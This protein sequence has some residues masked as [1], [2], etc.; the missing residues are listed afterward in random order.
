MRRL[1]AKSFVDYSQLLR[2]EP[3]KL[4][5]SLSHTFASSFGQT[6]L[7]ALFVPSLMAALSLSRTEFSG[8][9]SA[10]TLLAGMTI[11]FLGPSI[12]RI[13]LKWASALASLMLALSLFGLAS[14]TAP[15]LVVLMLF[16]VR[17]FGQSYMTLI[18]TTSA[19]RHFKETRGKSLGI[20]ALGHPLG[21]AAL[22]LL[23]TTA[24]AAWG[25]RM[26]LVAQGL[27]LLL[28]FWPLTHSLIR[29]HT[30]YTE[31]RQA[32][33]NSIA[34]GGV[35]SQMSTALS[36]SF[37][38]W[39]LLRTPRFV[40]PAAIGLMPAFFLTGFFFHGTS[41]AEAKGWP[42]P[43]LA[44]GFIVFAAARVLAGLGGGSLIDSRGAARLLPLHLFPL[45][46]AALVLAVGDSAFW[47]PLYFALCGLSAGLSSNV[48]PALWGEMFPA[49]Q[50]ARVKSLYTP[51]IV[52]ST[53][54]SPLLF[55]VVLDLP[56]GHTGLFWA[57]VFVLLLFLG[58]SFPVRKVC[59]RERAQDS[60][61]G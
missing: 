25:W 21:E 20:V 44:S 4:A 32:P 2:A 51:C 48:M 31:V 39:Q 15:W 55:G 50:L 16:L 11:P 6:F 12:D 34:E 10:A 13:D 7:I 60:M 23:V 28:L 19:A 26:T 3:A 5:F 14:F 18:A 24:I 52:V 43:A 42:L 53:A 46:G 40:F 58:A 41:L 45:F 54:L 29:R 47:I 61:N 37:K 38:R 35:P 22:P 36:P 57:S 27:F 49:H 8:L 1:L 9:Y 56:L 33:E 17:L 59:A 30:S